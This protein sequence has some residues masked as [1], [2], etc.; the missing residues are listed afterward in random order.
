MS[1]TYITIIK[2]RKH[3]FFQGIN[4]EKFIKSR[5]D[6]YECVLVTC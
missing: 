4:L 2:K 3:D 5:V 1:L 6:W